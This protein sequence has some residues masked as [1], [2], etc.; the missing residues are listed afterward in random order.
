V[1]QVIE[2]DARAFG[3]HQVYIEKVFSDPNLNERNR[4]MAFMRVPV[5]IA[6]PETGLQR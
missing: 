6:L 3:L 5:A 4:K 2:L 1:R